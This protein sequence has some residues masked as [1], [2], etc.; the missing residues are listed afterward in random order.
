MTRNRKRE[1][2]ELI[3]TLKYDELL[4][5]NEASKYILEEHKY[6]IVKRV[7]I[8]KHCLDI[9]KNKS[10]ELYSILEF[11]LINDNSYTETA[12]IY[13]HSEETVKRRVKEALMIINDELK[14]FGI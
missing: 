1:I 6:V 7:A 2:K 11:K 12:R 13:H 14:K 5:N 10:E 3:I 4:L 9:L 8:V